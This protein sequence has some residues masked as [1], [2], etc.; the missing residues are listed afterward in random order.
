M[1]SENDFKKMILKIMC[2][3]ILVKSGE[4]LILILDEKKCKIF[5]GF[6]TIAH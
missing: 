5:F 6:N 1:E 2:F 4:L 3:I